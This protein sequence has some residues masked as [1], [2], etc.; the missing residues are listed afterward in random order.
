MCHV[1]RVKSAPVLSFVLGGVKKLL[2]VWTKEK[3]LRRGYLK[4]ALIAVTV[5][6]LLLT[7]FVL[8][9]G[10]FAKMGKNYVYSG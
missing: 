7:I 6:L 5:G 4:K 3:M 1:D 9:S 10:R 2:Q 8:F